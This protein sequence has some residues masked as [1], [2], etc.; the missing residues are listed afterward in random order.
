[1]A[2]L[3]MRIASRAAVLVCGVAV[4]LIGFSTLA[5]YAAR[6]AVLYQWD[7]RVVGMAPNTGLALLLAGTALATLA[8]SNRV[9]RC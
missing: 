9:W 5:G 2:Q 3:H 4:A 8:S 6:D 1:M 7:E